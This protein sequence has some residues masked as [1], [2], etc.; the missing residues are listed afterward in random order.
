MPS[1]RERFKDG[2]FNEDA[3]E[4]DIFQAFFR[5]NF[6]RGAEIVTE[7]PGYEHFAPKLM[8]IFDNFCTKAQESIAFKENNLVVLN[9]GD[10]WSNNIMFKY[11]KETGTPVDAIFVSIETLN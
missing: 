1:I 2:F 4:S 11:D 8:N 3:F 9:H 10:L 5:K 6:K 7:M